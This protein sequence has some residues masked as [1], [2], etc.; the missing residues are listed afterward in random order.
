MS[1]STTRH[2]H[3]ADPLNP[4]FREPQLADGYGRLAAAA[5][6]PVPIPVGAC[7]GPH[8]CRDDQPLSYC[9]ESCSYCM[10]DAVRPCTAP[11]PAPQAPAGPEPVLEGTFAIYVTPEEALVVAYR[12]R[13]AAADKQF[14]VPAFLISM[15]TQRSGHSLAD[16]VKGLK[17]QG[18]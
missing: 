9:R 13:G 17:E 7:T 4:F 1:D 3:P 16:V 10:G 2:D 15:A 5:A 18:E 6:P 11:L 8:T 12:P 14:V